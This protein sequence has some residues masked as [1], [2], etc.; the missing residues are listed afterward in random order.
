MDKESATAFLT[1]G[2][3]SPD[4]AG[5]PLDELVADNIGKID[6]L[7][8]TALAGPVSD[9]MA[10]FQ[11]KRTLQGRMK[12]DQSK[13]LTETQQ[14]AG[15]TPF[16]PNKDVGGWER[17]MISF[18]RE[19]DS[20]IKYLQNKYGERNV[21]LDAR[22]NPMVKVMDE[23]TKQPKF[24]ST[25]ADKLNANDFIDL[26]GSAPEMAGSIIAMRKGKTL[27]G[28]TMK[29]LVLS[30]LGAEGAGALK[31]ISVEAVDTGSPDWVSIAKD[32]ATMV[33]VDIATG[34][35]MALFGKALGKVV[36][37]F[38]DKPG[39]IQYDA[40]TAKDY[41]KEKYGIDIPFS[42]GEQ[43][44]NTFLMRIEA[45]M[46]K[47][48]GAS[49]K[50]ADIRKQQ[51]KVFHKIQDIA[52]GRATPGESLPSAE[53]VGG[54][55]L[56]A[57]ESRIAPI[58]KATKTSRDAAVASADQSIRKVIGSTTKPTPELYKSDV[59][60]MIR[61][62]SVELRDQFE[63]E[64]SSLYEKAKSL[65]GG[66]D[67]ILESESLSADAA[68]ILKNDLP[69]KD[70]VKEV[71]TGLLDQFG[72][73]V[74]RTETGRE[75]LKEF[76]PTKI[77]GK[78]QELA[79]LKGQKF[80]LEDLI[81]MRNDVTNDI[82]IGE[83]IPGTQT[84]FLGK[85]RETLT[86]AISESTGKL[87]GGELKTAWEQANA[88]YRDNVGKFHQR[89]VS[90]ILQPQNSGSYV[91]DSEIVGRLLSGTEK[92]S[93]HFRDMVKFLGPDSPE[94]ASLKRSIADE[95][96]AKSS[97][98]GE[99]LIN[100]GAFLKNLESLYANNREIA[101]SVF[102][103]HPKELIALAR[104][105]EIGQNPNLK[106]DYEDLKGLLESS[107]TGNVYGKFVKAAQDQ[108]D[109]DEVYRN[110]IFKAVANRKVSDVKIEPEEFVDRFVSGSTQKEIEQVVLALH[111]N[112][113]LMQRIRQKTV[114]K[115]FYDSARHP[116]PTDPILLSQD[117]MRLPSTESL[118]K[119]IGDAAGQKKLR[120][121]LG[122]ETYR[123]VIEFAKVMK[124]GEATEKVFSTA[125]G[126]S[127]G[128]QVGAMLRGG[129]LSYMVNFLRYRVGAELVTNPAFQWWTKNKAM[130]AESQH[131]I[132]NALI[133][134]SP[135]IANTMV[136]LGQEGA[137]KAIYQMKQ[138]IDESM[139][140]EQKTK[141]KG[142][143][144]IESFL[145]KNTPRPA[146]AQ[147]LGQ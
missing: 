106:I 14:I 76:V 30:A 132:I 62:K 104:A 40:I 45:M 57:L 142:K 15:E 127:A 103:K 92:A 79:S 75:I 124:P 73:D 51:E 85:I 7:T 98:S 101:E 97:V 134:S 24:I 129:D 28:G 70:V 83:S 6:T 16:D 82:K 22:G 131:A 25:D 119:N 114:Q 67:R 11:R 27:A 147:E 38:G 71:P 94:V 109:L 117:Q 121:I 80:S 140:K 63:T 54:D 86:K 36:T 60:A 20:Q 77:V 39:P 128:M 96:M 99:K 105:S 4:D 69:A 26:I 133:A 144:E 110:K 125:G 56:S 87:E 61:K 112:P 41:F 2:K 37:P 81:Q 59:G 143:A 91:G 107:R 21:Q 102:G 68:S 31:D 1:G 123:N 139:S 35:A 46:S 145:K 113:E 18:R 78:L 19:K 72:G 138:S 141:L 64:S 95:I 135:F 17:L 108:A 111:D 136:D 84:H 53:S 50:V 74:T 13:Y 47:L 137:E 118:L 120:T 49:G 9:P 42:P 122:E 34:G 88:F 32:R 8:S 130:S 90:G 43:T 44:G 12:E 5:K 55:A 33:P 100:G 23:T 93:D 115:L 10:S 126:L 3:E 65:P 48:P 66:R 89:G 116:S 52:L 29:D 58:V 146:T